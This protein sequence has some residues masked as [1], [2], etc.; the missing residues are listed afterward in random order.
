MLAALSSLWRH[1]TLRR[2]CLQPAQHHPVEL[3]GRLSGA[4]NS[5][6]ATTV[7]SSI[8]Q[9]THWR[10]GHRYYY[11]GYYPSYYRYPTYSYYY[12]YP[13]YYYSYPSYGFYYAPRYRHHYRHYRRW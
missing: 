2:R 1:N 3:A 8:V 4:T 9:E 12:P 10:R 13:S 5:I 6:K 7:N 11:G